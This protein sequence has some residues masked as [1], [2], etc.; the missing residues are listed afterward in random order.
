MGE[1]HERGERIDRVTVA[2][3]LMRFNELESVRRP[4]LPGFA[5]RRPAADSQSRQLHPHRPDKATCGASPS[6]RSI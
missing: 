3:E 1:L 2:N 5:R 6:R 4:Q